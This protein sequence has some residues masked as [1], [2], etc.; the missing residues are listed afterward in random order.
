MRKNKSKQEREIVDLFFKFVGVIPDDNLLK[1]AHIISVVLFDWVQ[2]VRIPKISI[3]RFWESLAYLLPREERVRV[4]RVLLDEVRQELVEAEFE[5]GTK[6]IFK[7][8]RFLL[9]LRLAM[10]FIGTVYVAASAVIS[11]FVADVIRNLMFPG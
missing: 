5:Y 10:H 3:M 11:K 8:V 1:F 9:H 7:W 2:R 6:A 4:F